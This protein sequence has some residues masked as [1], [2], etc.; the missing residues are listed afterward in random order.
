M[1]KVTGEDRMLWL[2]KQHWRQQQNPA[3]ASSLCHR[4]TGLELE[5][6]VQ[7]RETLKP[8]S[9]NPKTEEQGAQP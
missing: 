7:S 2:F 4:G 5:H 1:S 8:R 3:S 9:Q 6:P